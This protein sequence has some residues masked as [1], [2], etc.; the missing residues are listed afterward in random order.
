MNKDIQISTIKQ[1]LETIV[2]KYGDARRTELA[3]IEMPKEEKEIIEVS[4]KVYDYFLLN[5]R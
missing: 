2:K 5:L 4:N 1:R 3:Q